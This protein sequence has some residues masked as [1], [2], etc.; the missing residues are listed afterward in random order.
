MR[1]LTRTSM[2]FSFAVK[3]LYMREKLDTVYNSIGPCILEQTFKN[4]YTSKSSI[5]PIL[6]RG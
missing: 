4:L 6:V 5:F 2:N 1:V 3:K